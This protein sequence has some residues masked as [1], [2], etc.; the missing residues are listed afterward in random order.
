MT[1][2]TIKVENEKTG[3]ITTYRVQKNGDV[4]DCLREALAIA[5]HPTISLSVK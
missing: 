4:A 5:T 2:W 1:Y 3:E